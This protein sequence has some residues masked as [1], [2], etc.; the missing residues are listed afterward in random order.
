MLD[1]LLK[2]WPEYILF[3]VALGDGCIYFVRGMNVPSRY[4]KHL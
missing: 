2:D 4:V 1:H 3:A